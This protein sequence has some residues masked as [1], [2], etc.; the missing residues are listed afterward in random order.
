LNVC[1]FD[2]LSDSRWDE[3]VARHPRASVFHQ[4]GW[5]EA[6]NR[7]YGYVPFVLTSATPGERLENG[8]VFCRVSSW[9]TGTRLVSLPFADHC[10]PLLNSTEESL[11]FMKWLR[12]EGERQ[13]C[14]YVEIRPLHPLAHADE[15]L[16][17]GDAYCFH[18]LDLCLPEA[19]LFEKL[20]KS[21]IQRKIR[22]AEREQL[23]YEA[24]RSEQLLDE[25]YRLL[26]ITRKR[27][28]VPPQPRMWFKNLL[29]CLGDRAL[30]RV[31]RKGRTPIA[32][33]LT[34]R[35]GSTVVYKYGGS[36]ERFHNLGGMP[37]LF[38]KLIQESKYSGAATIDFGRS[39]L[40][41]EGLVAFKDKWGTEQSTLT[42]YRYPAGKRHSSHAK[43]DSRKTR[44]FF[45]LLPDA[46][47]SLAGR[48]LYRHVG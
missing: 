30:I 38:W 39:D 41:N 6:L 46:F 18:W 26:V 17:A 4:R 34:L 28:C 32:A 12:A 24:G 3:L 25:F 10:E 11:E 40:E 37:L 45:A 42:Y 33:L 5:L 20:H 19:Q 29:E 23:A 8:I 35:H 1:T 48:I 16:H 14:K 22:R 2:P 27:H 44:Q 9:I 36:D 47:F 31:A 15:G 13:H 7:T 21:S 43:R